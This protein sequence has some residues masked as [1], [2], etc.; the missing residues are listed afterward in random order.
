MNDHLNMNTDARIYPMHTGNFVIVFWNFGKHISEMSAAIRV[1]SC[2]S[3]ESYLEASEGTLK[4]P[5]WAM[6]PCS[7]NDS[8]KLGLEPKAHGEK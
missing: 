3:L 8:C 6:V 4:G 1:L 7:I 2:P 5:I